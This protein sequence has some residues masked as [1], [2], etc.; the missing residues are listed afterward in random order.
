MD[1]D[2]I[3]DMIPE[4]YTPLDIAFS[5]K[6]LDVDGNVTLINGSSETLTAWEKVGMLTSALDDARDEMRI[7]AW[8]DDSEDD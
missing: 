7:P 4:G 5:V 2:R 1:D 8:S 3:S 6:C